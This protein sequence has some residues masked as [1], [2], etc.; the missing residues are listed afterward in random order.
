MT[1]FLTY[2][3][4]TSIVFALLCFFYGMLLSKLTFHWANRITLLLLPMVSLVLPLMEFGQLVP[5]ANPVGAFPSVD[6]ASFSFGSPSPITTDPLLPDTPKSLGSSYANWLFTTYLIGCL[7][8]TLKLG[9]ATKN[10]FRVKRN[11]NKVLVKN[12]LIYAA[13]VVAPLTYFRWIFVPKR[14]IEGIHP[15]ILKHESAHV[16]LGHTFD[17]LLIELYAVIFW[18]NPALLFFRKSLVALHEFQADQAVLAENVRPEDYLQLMLQT[19]ENKNKQRTISYF[20]NSIIKKRIDMITKSKSKKG[21]AFNY[22]LLVTTA[23]IISL[24]FARP[25]IPEETAPYKAVLFLESTNTVPNI[26]P[27]ETYE[28]ANITSTFGEKIRTPKT[29]HLMVHSGIDI[30][31]TTGTPVLATADGMVI[32]A[33]SEKNWGNLIVLKHADGY[34]TWYAHLNGFEIAEKQEVK[35]GDVIGYVGSTGRSTGPHLHYEVRKG[36][37]HLDPMDFFDK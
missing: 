2:L 13:P 9:F 25:A 33:K 30:R 7:S 28:P 18:F 35:T 34:Q 19:L 11:S 24:A 16:R 15:L 14:Q 21:K 27:L 8:V 6:L 1:D 4:Q 32:Q 26:F 3:I 36:D 5:F 20:N 17:L 10:I 12:T 22:S 23:I 31:A 37:E 29:K